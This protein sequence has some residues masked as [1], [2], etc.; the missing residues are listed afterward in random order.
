MRFRNLH[1]AKQLFYRLD[2]AAGELN[3]LLFVIALGLGI[4]DLTCLWAL[5]V[6]EA[7]PPM[8]HAGAAPSADANH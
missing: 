1:P 4:L 6:E 2:R 5:K 3:V 8:T 7:L